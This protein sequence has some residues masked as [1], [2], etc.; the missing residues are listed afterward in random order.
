MTLNYE[1]NGYSSSHTRES[2]AKFAGLVAQSPYQIRAPENLLCRIH[3]RPHPFLD[4]DRSDAKH[5]QPSS[6]WLCRSFAGRLL[7]WY[8]ILPGSPKACY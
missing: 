7:A 5:V 3:D 1:T 6:G 2:S 4:L 8:G